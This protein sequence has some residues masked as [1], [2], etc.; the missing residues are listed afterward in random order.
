MLS[1]VAYSSVGKLTE[2]RVVFGSRLS[3]EVFTFMCTTLHHTDANRGGVDVKMSKHHMAIRLSREF[4]RIT[5][6]HLPQVV[7]DTEAHA[8][9]M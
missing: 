6:A 8:Q 1:S 3:L 2:A 9:G 7:E 5:F 4:R